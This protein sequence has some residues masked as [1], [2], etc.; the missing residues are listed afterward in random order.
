[1]EEASTHRYQSELGRRKRGV[2]KLFRKEMKLC[3][4]ESN[5]LGV[6]SL[7]RFSWGWL[8]VYRRGWIPETAIR[9]TNEMFFYPTKWCYNIDYQ[10]NENNIFEFSFFIMYWL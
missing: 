9:L 10:Y 5:L 2:K 4:R 8:F 3:R 1:M 6:I 7:N